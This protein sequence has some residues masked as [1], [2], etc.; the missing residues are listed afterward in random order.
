MT[1]IQHP[2]ARN[3]A[4]LPAAGERFLTATQLADLL[5]VST[6]QIRRWTA[7]GMPCERWGKAT[8]RY[9]ASHAIMWLR[10][11]RDQGA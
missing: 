8:V 2:A 9:L 5:G 10:S 6:R 1:V 3:A 11:H 7:A 4:P